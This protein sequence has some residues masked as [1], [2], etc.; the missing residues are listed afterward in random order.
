V[1]LQSDHAQLCGGDTYAALGAF[2]VAVADV[3]DDGLPDLV[4]P[5]PR[6]DRLRRRADCA[7]G[8]LLQD[9]ANHGS[10]KPLQNCPETRFCA[11]PLRGSPGRHGG[12]SPPLP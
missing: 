6:R 8:V 2:Q 5:I 11:V 1:L 10:F 3:N 12:C 7:A 4:S 9:A